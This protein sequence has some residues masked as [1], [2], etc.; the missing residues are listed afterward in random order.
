MKENPGQ[1]TITYLNF[2]VSSNKPFAPISYRASMKLSGAQ[3]ASTG[4]FKQLATQS[5][6]KWEENAKICVPV[7]P[8]HI[9]ELG[10]YNLQISVDLQ[11]C[12]VIH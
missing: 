6:R 1:E 4:S 2:S 7:K 12:K 5:K 9:S 8:E 10:K 11:L 3:I